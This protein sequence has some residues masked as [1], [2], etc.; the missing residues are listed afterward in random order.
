[1][2]TLPPQYAAQT[3][4]L[5][6]EPLSVDK[7]LEGYHSIYSNPSQL[8]WSS[9]KPTASIADS[10]AAFLDRMRSDT[11]PW[12]QSYA[13]LLRPGVG[14]EPDGIVKKDLQQNGERQEPQFIGLLGTNRQSPPPELCPELGY[15]L[16]SDFFGHGYATEALRAFLDLYWT[17]SGKTLL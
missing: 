17:L 13:I 14:D 1:M 3:P 15:R 6:L 10:R 7:H 2:D 12:I 11:K 16:K 8:V 9:A 4:R 5:Y